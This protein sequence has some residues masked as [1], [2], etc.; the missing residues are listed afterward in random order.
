MSQAFNLF[1]AGN[2]LYSVLRI[3]KRLGQIAQSG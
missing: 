3:L 2:D 1:N